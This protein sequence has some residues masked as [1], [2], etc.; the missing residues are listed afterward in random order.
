MKTTQAFAA[1][2]MY[3]MALAADFDNQLPSPYDFQAKYNPAKNHFQM[4]W[5]IKDGTYM[6]IGF[7]DVTPTGTDMIKC[8]VNV[9]GVAA[10]FD[11]HSVWVDKAT[12]PEKDAVQDIKYSFKKGTVQGTTVVTMLRDL[13]TGDD[14]DFVIPLDTDFDVAWSVIENGTALDSYHNKKGKGLTLQIPTSG[15]QTSFNYA[16]ANDSASSML[17]SAGVAVAL[18]ASSSF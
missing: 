18:L 2:L 15:A 5:T 7:G 13:D 17:A 9:P 12:P 14:L 3:P 6:G 11:M 1:A 8:A 16:G 10:C 4:Q